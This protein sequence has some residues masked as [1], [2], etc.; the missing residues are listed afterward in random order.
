MLVVVVALAGHAGAER[1][2]VGDR[3]PPLALTDWAG[4]AVR[5]EDLG[6][7]VVC[8]DFWATW[9]ANCKP[10]LPALDAIGRRHRAAGLAVV[11]VNIDKA[12]AQ[13][14]RFLNALVPGP[15]FTLLHD[16]EGA[17]LARLGAAGMPALYVIDRAGVVRVAESGFEPGRL[18]AI[19]ATITRL[20]AEPAP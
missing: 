4:K 2:A 20:L 13:A 15:S 16:P 18:A 6:G 10:A 8:L 12:R 14:D 19:E 7:K 1:V 3:L 17:A 5:L 9:C 11:A